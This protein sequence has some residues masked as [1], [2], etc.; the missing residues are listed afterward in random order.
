MTLQNIDVVKTL[1]AGEIYYA[2]YSKIRYSN[3]K[4]QWKELSKY[5]GF[6]HCPIFC[7]LDGDI[8]PIESSGL[9]ES[10]ND[11]ILHLDVP[12][13][14]CRIMEYYQFSDYLYYSSGMEYDDVFN[15]NK[16]EALK[17]IDKYFK[18]YKP[19]EISSVENPQVCIEEIRPEWV[20][21]EVELT[22]KKNKIKI[23]PDTK[24]SLELLNKDLLNNLNGDSVMKNI[25]NSYNFHVYN[26]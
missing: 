9:S 20:I 4:K 23:I 8:S 15:F 26:Y 6:S 19:D 2:D 1:K 7:S 24:K 16:D 21:Q 3:Y 22:E 5:C 17:N 12:D 10:G 25:E 13:S 11:V 14:N 18:I